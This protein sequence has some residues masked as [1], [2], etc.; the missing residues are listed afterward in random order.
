MSADTTILPSILPFWQDTE[1]AG[2][3]DNSYKKLAREMK[4]AARVSCHLSC[5]NGRMRKSGHFVRGS[6]ETIKAWFLAGQLPGHFVRL[7]Q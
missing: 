3:R 6:A 1:L 5:Q 4:W 7:G 2:A